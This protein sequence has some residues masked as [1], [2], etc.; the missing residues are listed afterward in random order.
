VANLDS[1]KKR[2][3]GLAIGKG[4]PLPSPDGTIDAAD[5]ARGARVYGGETAS[6]G[7]LHGGF[8]MYGFAGCLTFKKT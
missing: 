7:G 4:R 6:S 5:R 2:E 1:R 8:K 3:Q